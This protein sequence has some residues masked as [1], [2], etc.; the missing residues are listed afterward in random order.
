VFDDREVRGDRNWFRAG[1]MPLPRRSRE[2]SEN[3]DS[4]TGHGLVGIE[5]LED[6]AHLDQHVVRLA[7]PVMN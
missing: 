1:M 5:D 6:P 7:R 4:T 3:S 2:T